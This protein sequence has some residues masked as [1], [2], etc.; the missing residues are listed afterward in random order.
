MFGYHSPGEHPPRIT[1]E[2]REQGELLR[3]EFYLLVT[4]RDKAGGW[5]EGKIGH[6]KKR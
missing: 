4:P 1:H 6:L 5:V 3:R 2:I